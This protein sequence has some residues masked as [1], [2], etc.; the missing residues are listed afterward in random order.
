MR[1]QLIG[2]ITFVAV[3]AVAAVPALAQGTLTGD[4]SV[5]LGSGVELPSALGSWAPVD[6]G[7]RKHGGPTIFI[8]R[9]AWQ[10]AC[11]DRFPL[12]TMEGSNFGPGSAVACFWP[13]T[14]TAGAAPC[15]NG[16]VPTANHP[17]LQIIAIGGGGNPLPLGGA[18]A[19][20]IVTAG[21]AGA[22]ST[23]HG[24]N[25]FT[26]GCRLE[27]PCDGTT[28]VG[29]DIIALIGGPA[30]VNV[31]LFDQD[32]ALIDTSQVLAT[33]GGA[34]YGATNAGGI[35]AVAYNGD[36]DPNN[37][38]DLFD[39]LEFDGRDSGSPAPDCGGG[40]GGN[41]GGCPPEVLE[42]IENIEA[43]LDANL[44][45]SVSSRASQTSVDM[46]EGKLDAM[47]NCDL[48]PLLLPLLGLDTL[49]PGHPC[50]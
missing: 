19:L 32:G 15:Y 5:N 4:R 8:S 23:L 11:P 2:L 1:R 22:A 35:G 38:G 29:F 28:C 49:P 36:G 30:F 17:D 16:M 31:D 50:E 47:D 46:I 33:T 34:F 45:V 3:V 6:S 37:T 39:S 24:T 14:W 12:L 18:Q 27:W 20:V 21:V 44:D 42:G 48:I 40:N 43:K 41:G 26:D 7:L 9:G 25:F 10:A 13:H